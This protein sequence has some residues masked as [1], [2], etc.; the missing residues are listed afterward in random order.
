MTLSGRIRIGMAAK[1]IKNPADLARRIKVNRQTVHK[2]LAGQVTKLEPEF[3]F[4]LADELG[5]DPRWLATR[6]GEP[7][8]LLRMS[9]DQK[10]VLEL[11]LALNPQLRRVWIKSGDAMLQETGQT[12]AAQPF[13]AKV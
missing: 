10:R 6:E 9:L 4:K 7:Q 11:Y 13:K 8:P 1:G 12:S 5:L 2:W 3:L